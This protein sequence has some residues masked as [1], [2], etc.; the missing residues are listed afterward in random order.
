MS[1]CVRLLRTVGFTHSR[2]QS[3]KS[4]QTS[5][6]SAS[7]T[8]WNS[9]VPIDDSISRAAL[10]MRASIQRSASVR[11]CGTASGAATARFDNANRVAFH[12]LFAKFRPRSNR[13]L[14]LRA[15][16]CSSVGVATPVAAPK[17]ETIRFPGIFGDTCT[18]S[19]TVCP[20]DVVIHFGV[21]DSPVCGSTIST[22]RRTSCV[23]VAIETSVKRIASEPCE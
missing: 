18:A 11:G 8:R 20:P 22:G 12:N 15:S 21:N 14:V 19:A 23:S 16:G 6:Y 4:R 2:Y 7:A 5:P 9:Y 3:Q 1:C 10:A 17:P 13:V